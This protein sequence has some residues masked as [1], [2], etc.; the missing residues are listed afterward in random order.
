VV[1]QCS[2]ASHSPDV[3]SCNCQAR[4]SLEPIFGL[5]GQK[6]IHYNGLRLVFTLDLHAPCAHTRHALFAHRREQP[7]FDINAED[8]E[9][10]YKQ[11]QRLLH[12]DKFSVGSQIEKEYSDHQVLPLFFLHLLPFLFVAAPA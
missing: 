6:A 12:P 7:R 1:I 2:I 3:D 8:L 10:R 9:Q 5:C 4:A 11:L